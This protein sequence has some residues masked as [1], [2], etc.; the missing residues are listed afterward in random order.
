[1]FAE[2]FQLLG[3]DE[4]VRELDL[5]L[6]GPNVAFRLHDTLHSFSWSHHTPAEH[7]QDQSSTSSSPPPAGT[8]TA[9]LRYNSG[10]YHDVS[11]LFPTPNAMFL[12]NAGLWGYDDWEPTLQR[13]FGCRGDDGDRPPVII[14][15]YCPEEASHDMETIQRVVFEGEEGCKCLKGGGLEWLWKPEVNPHR[16]LEPRQTKCGVEGRIL[17]ENQSW[18]ALRRSS[19]K[20]EVA[21]PRVAAET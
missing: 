5:L 8:L 17:F 15:S 13:V 14:T 20:I 9:T 16:S 10:L 1:M 21:S 6:C 7:E 4:R 18:Q 11:E 3:R 19:D 2:L 12:F